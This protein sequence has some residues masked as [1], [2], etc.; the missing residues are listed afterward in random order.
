[1][2]FDSGPAVSVVVPF[3][4]EAETVALLCGRIGEVMASQ[5]LRYE[6]VLVD[7]GST[8]G[9][10][11][12]AASLAETDPN[13]CLIQ[14]TRN[15]GKAA[16]LSAGFDAARGET[17]VTMDADLQDD[18]EEIP[19]FLARIGEGFDV[20]C[21]WKK[22]RHDPMG[23]TLP[24]RIFNGLTARA[25][26]IDI[27]DINCGFKAYSRRAAKS[28]N[29]YGELHRFTP[30]LLFNSGFRVAEIEVLHHPRTH[31]QSKYGVTRM[32]KGALDLVTVLL[33]TRYNARPLHFFAMLGLPLLLLGS[34]AIFYLSVLWL[35]GLGP[36]GNRPLLLIGILFVIAG[37]QLLGTGLIAELVHAVRLAE[38]DKYV[39][40]RVVGGR[41]SQP[42]ERVRDK[43]S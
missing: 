40:A 17:I 8:D 41:Q 14:F 42:A 26:G 30:A 10:G 4:N 38:S 19:R 35:L 22:K 25:F 5:G 21:G 18:P 27:H 29:L 32:I 12:I 37:I 11:D 24:S 23:K 9:G 1:M 34:L 7:D 20:V 15:F 2:Q 6:I 13:V 43:V 33:V 31:G 3:L 16:A 36:I 39:L 28:L